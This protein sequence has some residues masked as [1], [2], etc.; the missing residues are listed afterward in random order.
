MKKYSVLIVDDEALNITALSHML[1]DEYTVHVTKTGKEGLEAAKEMLP[2]IILL[3]IVMP[4]LNGYDVIET[5]RQDDET[6]DIP[7]IFVT[8]RG[9]VQD[10][11]LGLAL[12]AVDYIGKPFSAAIVKKRVANQLKILSQMRTISELSRTDALTGIGNRRHFNDVLQKEWSR[13][14]RQQVPLGFIILDIDN[15]K[16][17][18]D[19][20]GHLQGDV[21]LA[22]IAEIVKNGLHRAVDQVARWGGEEFAIILPDTDS[23]GAVSV[24]ENIRKAVEDTAFIL[25]DEPTYV[26]ISAGVH[27]VIPCQNDS[28]KLDNFVSDADTALYHAKHNGR[29][30]ISTLE[31]M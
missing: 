11:E 4:E 29:N 6:K 24:I 9:H 8:A 2:D 21:V 22:K 13:A 18:N 27:S 7:V 10:E 19:N 15:F 14:Q 3:D 16:N 28:Y 17:Y 31:D 25:N 26:T 20:Y 12:G 23:K 5:L 30:R 1:S